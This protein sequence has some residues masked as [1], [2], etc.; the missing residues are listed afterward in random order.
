MADLPNVRGE[1]VG[2]DTETCDRLFDT[3]GPGWCFDVSSEIRGGIVG[4]SLAVGERRVYLPFGHEDGGNLPRENTLAY[5]RD[6]LRAAKRVFFHNASYDCGWLEAEGLEIDYSKVHDTA[7]MA[8]MCDENRWKYSL[9]SCMGTWL[10]PGHTKD[11]KLLRDAALMYLPRRRGKLTNDEIKSNLWRFHSRYVGPYAEQDAWGPLALSKILLKEMEKDEVMR[12]Y[13]LEREMI[14]LLI[15]MRRRGVRV[16][17]DKA[18]QV[19]K[20]FVT[21][22]REALAEILRVTGCKVRAGVPVDDA[23]QVLRKVGV[24]PPK[25]LKGNDS[26]T[27]E[28]LYSLDH[29]IAKVIVRARKNNKAWRDF[30]DGQIFEYQVNG[31][32]HSSFHPLKSDDGGTVTGRFSSTDPNLQQVPSRDPE[33]GPLVRSCYVGEEGENWCAPDYSSQEPRW[34]VNLGVA[35]GE[36]SAIKVANEF[37]RN[38]RLDFHGLMTQFCWPAIEPGSKEFKGKRRD[39]KDMFLGLVYGMGGAKLCDKLGLP[40]D[41]WEAPDGAMRRVAGEAGREIINKFND[42]VPFVKRL[43]EK[44]RNAAETRGF[45]RTY[46]GRKCRLQDYYHKALNRIVQG[47]AAEQ[48]KAAT[49]AVWREFGKVPLLL[50]HDENGYSVS[51]TGEGKKI[52]EVMETCIEGL[53]VPFVVEP[54]VAH[55]WGECKE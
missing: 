10:G 16:D 11:E 51:D 29:P 55:S 48:A 5:V 15:Q 35:I 28:W 14:P 32:I 27:A 41:M 31:R 23:A 13:E 33:I 12:S 2:I 37:W 42:A 17:L 24:D 21:R 9:D 54:K 50:V 45:V 43:S 4:V 20:I 7:Y 3:R 34:T 38:P 49:L 1:D 18:D 46:F 22:E 39:A 8:A 6:S 40:T 25:T 19:K 30:I 26:V 53:H 47:S 44:A 52:C 36:Q